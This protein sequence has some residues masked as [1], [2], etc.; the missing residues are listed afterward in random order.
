MR[1]PDRLV[2]VEENGIADAAGREGTLYNW[3][4]DRERFAPPRADEVIE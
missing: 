1:S 4:V 2:I 3:V